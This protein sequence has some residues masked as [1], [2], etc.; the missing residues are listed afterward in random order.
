MSPFCG[1]SGYVKQST[2]S[3]NSNNNIHVSKHYAYFSGEPRWGRS[4]HMTLTY[5]FSGNHMIDYLSSDEVRDAFQWSF[6]RWPAVIPVNFT[7]SDCNALRFQTS[8]I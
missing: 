3:S 2:N 4:A 7:E 1:M 6:S 5:A 8:Y